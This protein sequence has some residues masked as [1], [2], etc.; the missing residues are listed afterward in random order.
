MPG[1]MPGSIKA[2]IMYKVTIYTLTGL[3]KISYC[4]TWAEALANST[5]SGAV[6]AKIEKIY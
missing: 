1:V 4:K 5:P 2:N 6:G 3:A